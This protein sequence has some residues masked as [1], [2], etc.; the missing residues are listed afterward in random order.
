MNFSQSKLKSQFYES[1]LFAILEFRKTGAH[2]LTTINVCLHI[3]TVYT[4]NYCAN[5]L[6]EIPNFVS[7][8]KLQSYFVVAFHIPLSIFNK[9]S[10]DQIKPKFTKQN[11]TEPNEDC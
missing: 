10:L 2:T 5:A 11:K 1:V 9:V 3:Y 4:G 7:I 6:S 8:K